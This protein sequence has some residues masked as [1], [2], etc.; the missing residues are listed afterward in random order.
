MGYGAEASHQPITAELRESDSRRSTYLGTP[1]TLR[2]FLLIFPMLL[3]Q[4]RAVA[5]KLP[6]NLPEQAHTVLYRD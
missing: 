2:K 5:L 3:Q 6:L 1:L 4:L